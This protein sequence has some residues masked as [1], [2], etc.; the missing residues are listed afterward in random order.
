MIKATLAAAALLL[1]AG[2]ATAN[3]A[4]VPQSGIPAASSTSELPLLTV[5]HRPDHRRGHRS[6]PPRRWVAGNRYDRSPPG[7]HRHSKRPGDWRRR[8]CVIVGPV[9]FCP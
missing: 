8:G 6:P 1:G 4:S 9:W 7:W 3:A 5:Q 2:F